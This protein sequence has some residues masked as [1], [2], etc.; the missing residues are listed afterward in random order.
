M[1]SSIVKFV[2]LISIGLIGFTTA[3]IVIKL[4]NAHKMY[5]QESKLGVFLKGTHELL[6]LNS[7]EKTESSISGQYFLFIGGLQG[8]SK[9]NSIVKFIWKNNENEYLPCELPYEKVRFVLSDTEIPTVKFRWSKVG[10]PNDSF[11]AVKNY[12]EQIVYAVFTINRKQ[13]KS[14]VTFDL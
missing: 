7:E 5:P 13:I 12:N 6:A 3:N 1:S 2:I 4:R 10:Y 8:G 9:T 11:L 14:D